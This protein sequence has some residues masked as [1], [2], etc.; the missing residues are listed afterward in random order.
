MSFCRQLD[1]CRK[2]VQ[3][4]N[5]REYWCGLDDTGVNSSYSTFSSASH[6]CGNNEEKSLS[7][8]VCKRGKY[9]RDKYEW[10]MRIEKAKFFRKEPSE[11]CPY[12]ME[13]IVMAQEM[14]C[15]I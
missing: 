3:Y 14:G 2:C 1:I 6:T 11:K 12:K 7:C 5:M 13:Q 8:D 9:F 4:G 10:E 15:G